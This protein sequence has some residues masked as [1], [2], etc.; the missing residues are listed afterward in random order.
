VGSVVCD[1]AAAAATAAGTTADAAGE[2]AAAAATQV[3]V[4]HMRTAA[5]TVLHCR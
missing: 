5:R 1:V 3:P 4:A 2:A